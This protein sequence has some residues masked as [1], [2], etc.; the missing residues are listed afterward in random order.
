MGGGGGEGWVLGDGESGRSKGLV[1][2]VLW[3][4]SMGKGAMV[5]D[6]KG[7]GWCPWEVK[8]MAEKNKGEESEDGPIRG[9]F[10]ESWKVW[11]REPMGTGEYF[12]GG[13]VWG[14]DARDEDGKV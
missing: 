1:K 8:K 14:D 6:W 4:G 10:R 3:V 9:D 11:R 13:G 5:I 2:I 12:G 7:L